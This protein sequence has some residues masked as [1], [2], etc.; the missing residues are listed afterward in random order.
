MKNDESV[1]FE[2]VFFVRIVIAAFR[3][4]CY[5]VTNDKKNKRRE[6]V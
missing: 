5:I 4:I 2:I 3:G 6:G 1:A